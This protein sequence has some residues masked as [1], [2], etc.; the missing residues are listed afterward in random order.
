MAPMNS[1]TRSLLLSAA[2]A[3]FLFQS[4]SVL[5]AQDTIFEGEGNWNDDSLWDFGIPGDGSTAIVNGNCTIT[6]DTAPQNS[7]NPSEIVIGDGTEGFLRVSGGTLSGA[8]GGSR[9]IHVGR[10]DGGVGSLVIDQGASF[11]SQGGG[12]VVRIGDLD[13]GQG[14]VVVSGEL[15][16]FKFFEL[17]NGTLEMMPTGV[18]AKF[19][20]NDTLSV[21]GEDGTLSYVIDGTSV[22]P[23]KKADGTG[24]LVLD[25]EDGANLKITLGGDFKVGDSWTLMTYS[26]LSGQFT[27]GETFTN[28]QGYTFTLDYGS[29]ANSDMI[30]TL[31]SEEG[32]PTISEFSATPSAAGSGD[33]VT[34]AWNVDKFTTLAI[35]GVG[36]VTAMG[37]QGS[38]VVNPTETT[39]Y[40]L[41]VDFDDVIVTQDLTVVVDALPVI[42]SLTVAPTVTSPGQEATLSWNTAGATEITLAPGIGAVDAAGS[43]MVSP[44]ETTTYLLTA[45]NTTG[46]VI[47]EVTLTVDAIAASLIRSYDAAGEGQTDGGWLDSILFRNYDMKNMELVTIGE[48]PNTNLTKAYQILSSTND[49]GGDNGDGFPFANASFEIW[50]RTADL[51]DFR[52]IIFETGG[53]ANGTSLSIDEEALYFW[54]SNQDERT[55]D[56]MVSLSQLNIAD[57]FIQVVLSMDATNS[58]ASIFARGAAGG[59][60]MATA[61]GSLGTPSGRSAIFRWSNF[62]ADVTGALG[63]SAGDPPLDVE[64]FFG[65]VALI[66]VYDRPLSEEEAL[67]AFSRIATNVVEDDSDGDD[68][69]DFWE[70]AL[71]GDLA[72]DADD[73]ND[74]DTLNNAAELAAGTHPKK[75]D[76]DEDGL[77]DGAEVN[78]DPATDPLVADTDGDGRSDGE[79]VNGDPTSDPTKRDTDGDGFSDGFEVAQGSNPNSAGDVPDDP[80]GEPTVITNEIGALPTFDGFEG[81]LDLVDVTFRACVDF[82][83]KTDPDIEVIFETGGG[84]IGFSLVYE[85]GSK[86]VLRA[87]GDGG[88]GLAMVERPLTPAEIAGGPLDLVW[89]FDVEDEDGNQAIALF[90]DG[91]LAGADS[92]TPERGLERQ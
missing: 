52:Q 88:L 77:N 29:G 36:D 34:L 19:N 1:L 47:E 26:E 67:D 32:R 85:E 60:A 58:K 20:Q 71:L 28:Q 23:L 81:G 59:S 24:G 66:N 14:T 40:T 70:N 25:I 7:L 16:N 2:A 42:N 55:I 35:S 51:D 13:G 44:T 48:S 4:G 82:D 49:T 54:H 6:E 86:L 79:E 75:A 61:E 9:G 39:T 91:V 62:G 74:A 38:V 68:L 72:S 45:K 11:R 17:L 37:A 53:G 84:T 31:T 76:T 41:T 5:I 3:I 30:L 33:P 65:Q 18:N 63:G 73:D 78:G 21:I 69:P 64:S 83:E 22:G 8:H 12:M 90:V 57:D 80:L 43:M 50:L 46:E 89:T 87:S 10:G 56:L 15:L 92:Q 27:Q